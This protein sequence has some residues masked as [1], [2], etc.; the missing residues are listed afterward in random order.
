M[1]IN[2]L[3]EIQYFMSP[4]PVPIP[5]F[6]ARRYAETPVHHR[7]LYFTKLYDTLQKGLQYFFQ[8][9]NPVLLLTSSGSGAMQAVM[10]SVL[11]SGEKVLVTDFGKFGQR[12]SQMA[13]HL[14]LEVHTCISPWGSV[15]HASELMLAMETH[16]PKAVI[17]THS[18]TS[19]GVL[20][21]LEEIC[22]L[23]RKKFPETLIIADTI[24][25]AGIVPFYMD[26]WSVDIALASSQKA[27][28]NPAGLAC[29]AMSPLAQ[30]QLKK[31]EGFNAF[32]LSLYLSAHSNS[33]V[34]VTP[35]VQIMMG[36]GS[37]LEWYAQQS[38]PVVWNQ[39]HRN[40]KIFR[41]IL[42]DAGA[43]LPAQQASD[44]L[45]VFGF[46]GKD[47]K[48]IQSLLLQKYNIQA[49]G[50]QEQYAGKYLRVAHFGMW[51]EEDMRHIAECIVACLE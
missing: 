16:T 5:D 49:E 9:Q 11:T 8:T 29:I 41:Q 34:P 10:Q 38:L 25:S 2:T 4:G 50:G 14:G 40:A 43:E 15:P 37:A 27:L 31:Q 3:P 51:K 1:D 24:S 35:S 21:D 23:I 47:M 20:L 28:M 12:W 42:L 36:T 6:I 45:T 46:P 19:T 33:S 17:F 30:K 22:F 44:T 7:S 39:V 26:A 32:D 18:E 48:K 13:L